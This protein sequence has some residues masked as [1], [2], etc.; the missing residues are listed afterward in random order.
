MHLVQE[1][2]KMTTTPYDFTVNWFDGSRQVVSAV[3]EYFKPKR[4]LEI[5]S[6]EGQ[7]TCHFIEFLGKTP[8]GYIKCIDPWF[9]AQKRP[10]GDPWP[11]DAEKIYNRFKRNTE[12]ARSRV[13]NAVRVDHVR[14]MSVY[15]LIDMAADS[16]WHDDASF[17]LVYIDGAHDAIN[18]L[19]D[20][21]L[22]FQLLSVGGVLVFDDYLWNIDNNPAHSP[23]LAIDAFTT[24]YGEKL[25]PI[26]T[27]SVQVYAEKVAD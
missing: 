10:N 23:K 18:V 24:I 25:K 27:S 16:N 20:A 19:R 14:S 11:F 4:I 1:R 7:S 9:A 5:G 15:E 21:V 8:D 6:F 2:M 26:V 13:A 12:I 22:S 3:L 17:D